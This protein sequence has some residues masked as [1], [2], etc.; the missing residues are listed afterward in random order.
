[1]HEEG[2]LTRDT[3][4]RRRPRYV[5]CLFTAMRLRRS[6]LV[7]VLAVLVSATVVADQARP[8]TSEQEAGGRLVVS[9]DTIVVVADYDAA[10][11]EASV[12]TKIETPLRETPR[13]V[14]ITERRT[15]DDRLA[16]NITAAHDYS[17]SVTPAD[18]RGLAF[19]RGF[20]VSLF[21]LRRDGLRTSAWSVREPVALE[22]VQYLRGPAAILYGDGS[23]GAL[24]NMV[25]RK[26]LPVQRSELTASAG[27]LGFGRI[28]GDVT[29]PLTGSRRARY[30]LIGAAEWLDNGFDNDE[31]RLSVLPMVALDFS[32]N[33][34]LHVDGELYH[35][36]GRNYWHFVPSTP[37]TQRGD[38][39]RMPWDLNTASP[40]DGWSGWNA[41]P[42]AR[43]DV[44]LTPQTS[45]HS[46]VRYTKMNG[47]I[48]GQGLIGLL[49]DGR[50]LARY[51]YVET[52]T[53]NETQ[54]DTF[55]T[56]TTDRGPFEH[57]L[58]VGGEA[59]VTF[60][61]SEIGIGPG[62]P[63]DL[64]APIY[65]PSQPNPVAR[66]GAFDV[67]RFGAYVQDQIRLHPSLVVVPGLRWSRLNIA[68]GGTAG[69]MFL[70]EQQ[71]SE[72][73]VSPTLGVVVL[74][75]PWFSIYGNLTQ[76]FEPPAPG[77][78]LEDG[79]GLSV[80]D[81]TS[82][83]GGVK[84]NARD[85]QLAASG[86]AYQIKRTNIAEADGRGF[87][88]Q[89][90]GG[91]SRGVEAE[92]TGRL[93]AGLYVQAAYAW[94]DTEI[95]HSAVG[96]IGNDLPNAPHH[97]AS[98]WTRYRSQHGRLAG[99]MFAAGIVRVSDRFLAGDNLVIAPA[100]TRLD[101]SGSY[102]FDRQRLRIGVAMPNATDTRYVTSGA[103]V[104]LY[105][106]QRR[107]LLLQ[108]STQ[109]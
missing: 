15:L 70:L 25:L 106:G 53:W 19:S 29:G 72:V 44:K 93:A 36:T 98:I 90:G 46:A 43:L 71:S 11:T 73:K 40:D 96:N 20:S 14:S 4:T 45:L 101:L 81:A 80:S 49:P 86:S 38:F 58:V 10:P 55:L 37:D 84:V 103:G 60:S 33:V 104:T 68:D 105:A 16:V 100:Y 35:Q 67:V 89:I 85:G 22:R 41:S 13:G 83:E 42:G 77:R 94:T 7:C 23:P 109:F 34:T 56:T 108:L 3:R 31:R 91:R 59:G 79:R 2:H 8:A 32:D 63:I 107:R 50:T 64:Y 17:V 61:E 24:I 88:Q 57:K 27:G 95:T 51:D 47:N 97:I 65:P 62:T 18:E 102:E 21:D 78:Y 69:G 52:S 87:Y 6:L 74:A 99:A 82:F 92:L 66:P 28:T 48:D 76:G 54:S 30:R 12:A 1:M 9:G 5:L 26:P 39:S 75:R